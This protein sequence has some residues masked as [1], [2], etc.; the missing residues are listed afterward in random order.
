MKQAQ[1]NRIPL[2]VMLV[3]ISLLFFYL[4]RQFIM[5]ILLAG[6]FSAMAQPI[7]QKFEGWFAGRRNLA[8]LTT[9]FI[10]FLIIFLPLLAVLGIVAQQAIRISQSVRPWIQKWLAEPTAFGEML[11]GLPFYDSLYQ[12]QNVILQRLGEVVGGMSNALIAYIQSITFSTLYSIFLFFVF[13]YTMFFLLQDGKRVLQ[14]ILYYL[15]LPGNIEQRLLERFTSVTRAAIKGTLVI[16]VIQGSLAGMAFWVVGIDS[17]VF[18]GTVMTF[19][20][21][22]PAVGAALV[23]VPAVIILAF[24]GEVLRALGLLAFCGLLVSSVD[25]V[26]RP[27][28]VGRD[29]RLHELLIFFSTLGGI[30]MFGLVGFIIGPI[31]AALFVT[32]WDIYAQTF[33]AYLSDKQK[34]GDQ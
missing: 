4:I 7:Y 15:P 19:L 23:W 5:A 14:R 3:L 21:I 25:N 13:L 10:V 34:G 16:G 17:A 32:I 24:S 9:L 31:I 28:L 30:S 29:I 26:L 22:I 2:I 12:Y 20:S 6:I 33:N 1:M 8:S 18:W 27:W 11:K